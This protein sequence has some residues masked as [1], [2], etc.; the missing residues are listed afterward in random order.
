V[1]LISFKVYH[2]GAFANNQKMP[3][4][5]YESFDRQAETRRIISIVD[6]ARET[7]KRAATQTVPSWD[8][9]ERSRNHGNDLSI[10]SSDEN[11]SVSL[12]HSKTEMH[13]RASLAALLTTNL[14][15]R[16]SEL[17]L[18]SAYLGENEGN[19]SHKS[20]L[21][22]RRTLDEFYYS[23]LKHDEIEERDQSQILFKDITAKTRSH[24][25]QL[26]HDSRLDEILE[27]GLN[28]MEKSSLDLNTWTEAQ[29]QAKNQE[30]NAKTEGMEPEGGNHP[31]HP[32]LMV[33]QLWMWI[34]GNGEV[35]SFTRNFT[36]LT[37][38]D[39]LI[40]CF[41]ESYPDNANPLDGS[42]RPIQDGLVVPKSDSI[43]KIIEHDLAYYDAPSPI[44]ING[45]ASLIINSC[46]KFL[47]RYGGPP[48]LPILDI[49]DQTINKAVCGLSR[50]YWCRPY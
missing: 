46:A 37:S 48:E 49:F 42:K 29:H 38:I 24:N 19:E 25:K 43:R 16:I 15:Y 34:I 31:T 4:I 23:S 5:H 7:A 33:D 14:K 12:M 20:S 9:F 13:R 8:P 1:K 22:V 30:E 44:S 26:L 2:N 45:F 36:S 47:D 41:P 35:L 28:S 40:T 39:T 27:T 32:I 50:A 21:H 17:S 10:E 18:I 6:E 3:Y 11:D